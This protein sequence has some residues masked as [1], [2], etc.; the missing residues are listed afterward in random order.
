MPPYD[1]QK[2]PFCATVVGICLGMGY[3]FF[4]LPLGVLQQIGNTAKC[5]QATFSPFQ[6]GGQTCEMRAVFI[7]NTLM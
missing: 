4:V 2:A 1:F 3:Y 7:S 5:I 6:D